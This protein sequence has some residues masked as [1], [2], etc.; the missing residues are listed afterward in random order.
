MT[1]DA[2]VAVDWG[3]TSLRIARIAP[4]GSVLEER[5]SGRGILSVPAGGFPAVLHET[6]GDWLAG[7][8]ALCLASGMAG[9]RQGWR[10]APYIACPAGFAE[11][12]AGLA[13]VEPARIAL[14][15]GLSCET[16]GVP[17]VIRGEEVQVFGAM[18]LL[19]LD[20]GVFVLPG[21]H[22]KWVRVADRRVQSF[23]TFMT[24][25]VYALLRQHSILARMMPA[26]DGPLDEDAFVRGV[27]HAQEAQGLLH[28]A[29][30]A[31][32][33]ALFERMPQPALPSYLSGLVI[34]EELRMRDPAA[35][36]LVLVG[37]P[38]LT[39][40]YELGLRTL[41]CAARSVG[42]Q[43]TWRGLWALART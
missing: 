11:L 27:R 30:S 40:R 28:G 38:L 5:G 6:C 35:S 12:A 41:G 36:A 25:E 43:A 15:P 17:D 14:V 1:W 9:S 24:G 39:R 8:G 21:T 2:L 19:R 31:R 37:N 32:T 34:G 10:E 26:D 18:D 29:F 4:D 16:R 20:D 3:T 22:S 42:A 13:W 33:L 7:A 23:A